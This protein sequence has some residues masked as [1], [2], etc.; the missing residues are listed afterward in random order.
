MLE[1]FSF[2]ITESHHSFMICFIITSTRMEIDGY[3][4]P[5]SGKRNKFLRYLNSSEAR[6]RYIIYVDVG[7]GENNGG[8]IS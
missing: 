8:H 3:R 6:L 7:M 5:N 4:L 1:W 2:S